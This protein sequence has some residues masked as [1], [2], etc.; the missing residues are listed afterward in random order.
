MI[1]LSSLSFLR[2]SYINNIFIREHSYKIVTGRKETMYNIYLI[3]KSIVIVV[4]LISIGASIASSADERANTKRTD[5]LFINDCGY[6]NQ[7]VIDG[8]GDVWSVNIYTNRWRIITSSREL[9]VDNLDIAQVVYTQQASQVIL[10]LDVVGLIENRGVFVPYENGSITD[11]N[12]VEYDFQLITS[13]QMYWIAYCN[14]TCRLF[15]DDVQVNLTSSDFSVEGNTL[16][17][18][19]SLVHPDE[20]YVNLSVVSFFIKANLSARW[21]RIVAMTDVA[22]SYAKKVFLFGKVRTIS[23][24]S[25]NSIVEAVNLDMVLLKRFQFI[26]YTGGERII[27]S[28]QSTGIMTT[29]GVVIG[30]FYVFID[31]VP[32][33]QSQ[34]KCSVEYLYRGTP[35]SR[36]LSLSRFFRMEH[37]TIFMFLS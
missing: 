27:F 37:K 10:S 4:I 11:I 9:N 13:E 30:F 15:Y 21:P 7:T 12:L 14:S 23:R 16:S 24:E 26:H 1:F 33:A 28:D 8:T 17:I 3:R 31:C 5:A 6:A 18:T 36:E 35:I 19:F 29:N 2:L 34:A 32:P 25:T 22:P 20:S